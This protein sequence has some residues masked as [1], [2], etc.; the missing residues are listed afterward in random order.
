V[1]PLCLA[2]HVFTN[3]VNLARRHHATPVVRRQQAPLPQAER[4]RLT[5]SNQST[6]DVQHPTVQLCRNQYS[7]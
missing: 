2:L 4:G 7:G 5:L 3:D 6:L 1:E